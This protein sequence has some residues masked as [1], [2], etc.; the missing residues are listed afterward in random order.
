MSEVPC[1]GRSR[2]GKVAAVTLLNIAVAA[3]ALWLPA[4]SVASAQGVIAY[5]AQGQTQDQQDR[6]RYEC[7]AWAVQQ[8]GFDPTQQVAQAPPPSPPPVTTSPLRGAGRGAAIGAV[9][10]AIGGDAG[11]GAA[12][13]AASGALIG[14]IR[15]REQVRQQQAYQQQYAA[16]NG[17]SAAQKSTYDRAVRTCLQGRG[18]TVD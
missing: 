9:G 2:P 15:R 11:K 18:Y 17:S 8:S 12:I 6:D 14:G 4:A 5:P 13:G 1:L 3:L 7:H 16:Q 10:G